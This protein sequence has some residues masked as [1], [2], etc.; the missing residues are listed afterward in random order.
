MLHGMIL[1]SLSVKGILSPRF[2]DEPDSKSETRSYDDDKMTPDLQF[3]MVFQ[4]NS[5]AINEN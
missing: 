5:C 3:A 1:Q 4:G 2:E